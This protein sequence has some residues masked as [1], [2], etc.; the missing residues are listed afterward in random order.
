MSALSL[1]LIDILWSFS[2]MSATAFSMPCFICTGLTPA[3]TA[4]Q[5][6]V[7]NRFGQHGGGGR[8]VT[9]HVAGLAGH[10]ADHA[11]AHV[12]VDVFQVDFLGHRDAVLGDGRASQSSS[13]ESRCGPW[14]R[15][16]P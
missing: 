13:A 9:R 12:L 6:F 16:S 4:S 3:T 2:V 15:A 14:D 5:T 10:F 7:E 8:A 11:G 1:I